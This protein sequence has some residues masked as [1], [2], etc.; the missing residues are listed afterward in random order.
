MKN[1]HPPNYNRCRFIE[2]VR[3]VFEFPPYIR[4]IPISS[5]ETILLYNYPASATPILKHFLKEYQILYK[6]DD[7]FHLWPR[8]CV[9][10]RCRVAGLMQVKGGVS[11]T[12]QVLTR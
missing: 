3:F 4:R 6:E 11:W 1:K 8:Y 2:A 7:L 9:T 12:S 10:A 5:M